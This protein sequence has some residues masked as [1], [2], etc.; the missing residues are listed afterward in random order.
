[1]NNA[2]TKNSAAR[3]A[4]LG[5]SI[6]IL[7]TLFLV[8]FGALAPESLSTWIPLRIST[9]PF[10][11]AKLKYQIA[12]FIIALIILGVVSLIFP[13]NARRFYKAGNL[14]APAEPVKWLGIKSTDTWKTI[15]RNFSII[16]SL[17]TGLFI[18]LN[19]AKGLTLSLDFFGY[20]PLI[21]ILAA[22]NAFTEEAI[23]R[24]SLV[25]ALDGVL[26]RPRIYIL[27]AV[28]FGVPHFFGVPGGIIGLV[29]A[30]FLGWLLAKS[31]TETEGMFWAWF[32]HFL[33]DVIIFSGLFITIL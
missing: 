21:L 25:T 27:S 12:S 15:G 32:I 17:A 6:V 1:V 14:G 11:D 33:Q 10:I 18:Y 26:K 31:I 29:M 8:Y 9:N 7:G 20:L 23:T 28:I 19:V 13:N 24:L 16:V 30:G 5:L 3:R 2:A 4:L 22:M